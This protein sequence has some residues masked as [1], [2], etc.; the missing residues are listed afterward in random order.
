MKH[1]LARII[2]ISTD[3]IGEGS[4]ICCTT[5]ILNLIF[6][7]FFIIVNQNLY[8]FLRIKSYL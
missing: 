5:Y 8:K 1:G 2:R 6:Y 4:N 7:P 3:W